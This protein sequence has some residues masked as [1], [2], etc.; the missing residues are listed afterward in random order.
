MEYNYDKS[1][2][3]SSVTFN[4]GVGE[5]ATQKWI[6]ELE[7]GYV[8]LTPEDATKIDAGRR[9]YSA[10]TAFASRNAAG[11][12]VE[13]TREISTMKVGLHIS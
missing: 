1:S 2:L 3:H 10:L 5:R 11:K 7:R 13:R 9:F 8:E 4:F 6:S 12:P